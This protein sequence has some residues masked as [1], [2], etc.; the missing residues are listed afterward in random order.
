MLAAGN[1]TTQIYCNYESDEVEV[2]GGENKKFNTIIV[3]TASY[4]I[5]CVLTRNPYGTTQ[6]AAAMY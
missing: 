5:L 2:S 1:F 4:I 6:L 3:H